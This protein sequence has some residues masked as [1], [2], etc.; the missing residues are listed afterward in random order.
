MCHE[1]D[2]SELCA[3]FSISGVSNTSVGAGVGWLSYC[4][5]L[6]QDGC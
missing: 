4:S 1:L 2:I 5:N 3:F 6:C